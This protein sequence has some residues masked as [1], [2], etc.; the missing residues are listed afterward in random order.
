MGPHQR[1]TKPKNTTFHYSYP[2]RDKTIPP[3]KIIQKEKNHCSASISES[4]P[5]IYNET[6]T[7]YAGCQRLGLYECTVP[8]DYNSTLLL[9]SALTAQNNF[10]TSYTYYIS[11]VDVKPTLYQMHSFI[12]KMGC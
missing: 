11:S 1:N 12:L 8:Q 2:D 7:S 6:K 3:L 5:I 9:H 4:N 10:H